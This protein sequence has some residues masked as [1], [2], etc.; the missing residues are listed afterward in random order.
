MATT[1]RRLVDARTNVPPVHKKRKHVGGGH[2]KHQDSVG[3]AW[4]RVQPYSSI[5]QDEKARRLCLL[6]LRARSKVA[7]TLHL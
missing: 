3:L 5:A 4:Q 1:R 2:P 6:M 7:A